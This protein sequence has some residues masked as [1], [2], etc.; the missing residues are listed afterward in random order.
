MFACVDIGGASDDRTTERCPGSLDKHV[1]RSHRS[2]VADESEEIRIAHRHPVGIGDREREA[3]ALEQ[4]AKAAGV[5]KGGDAR[6]CSA[7]DLEFRTHQAVA[8]LEQCVAPGKG[9]EE[10]AVGLQHP[11]D[12]DQGSG[13]IVDQMQGQGGGDQIEARIGEWRKGVVDDEIASRS[14]PVPGKEV[15]ADHPPD[16]RV[17]RKRCRQPPGVPAKVK[18]ER[19]VP[20]HGEKPVGKI[21]HRVG[22][23]KIRALDTARERAPGDGA[24]GGAGRKSRGPSRFPRVS[25]PL[26][27]FP[28]A[29][30]QDRARLCSGG[31]CLGLLGLPGQEARDTRQEAG[32]W[33]E[34][35]AWTSRWQRGLRKGRAAFSPGFCAC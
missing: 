26:R 32:K 25:G 29:W 21:V 6:G 4:R 12:L 13:Q 19:E 20:R 14:R 11:A 8:Q 31:P 28:Q 35:T 34:R 1:R 3:R 17:G 7:G 15:G 27:S 9:G 2:Q 23:K 16:A 5:G 30:P 22:E 10:Q 24:P 18:R 33:A